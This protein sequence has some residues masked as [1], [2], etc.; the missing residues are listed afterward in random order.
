LGLTAFEIQEV[1]Q[2]VKGSEDIFGDSKT[3]KV[4]VQA[5]LKILLG[6]GERKAKE[7]LDEEI[8]EKELAYLLLQVRDCLEIEG[9]LGNEGGWRDFDVSRFG[10]EQRK[11]AQHGGHV[12]DKMRTFG[13]QQQTISPKRE[14]AVKLR[15]K[16]VEKRG[17]LASKASQGNSKR[18]LPFLR[19]AAAY[20]SK[21]KKVRLVDANDGTGDNPGGLA[22]WYTRVK[23]REY[24]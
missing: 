20:K 22:D 8:S 15:T 13:I 3:E 12:G 23:L 14:G 9:D 1:K 7:L 10:K 2:G 18:V 11:L 19:V 16:D 24:K 21:A 5:V 17:R 6:I 4:L